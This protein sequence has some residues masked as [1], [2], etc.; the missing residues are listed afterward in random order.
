MLHLVPGWQRLFLLLLPVL[1]G[2]VVLTAVLT[3]AP[4]AATPAVAPAA[5]A[6]PALP[7]PSG[8]LVHVS[9]AVVKPGLY[10]LQRGDR[11]YAAIAAAGGLA[12]GADSTRLPGLAGRLKD[13]EQVKVPFAK[14]AGGGVVA[15]K[16]PI[17]SATAEELAGVPGFTPELARAVV[18]Y[19]DQ[20]GPLAKLSELTSVLGM[21]SSEYALAKK[22]LTLG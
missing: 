21:G 10:R 17:N 1:L 12:P 16:V 4:P 3:L 14:G 15:A 11:V 9:G 8:L 6:L 7:P 2:A 18:D 13:G 19:R 22:S 5:A 20:F